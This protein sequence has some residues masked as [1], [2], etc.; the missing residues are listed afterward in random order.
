MVEEDKYCVDILVQ[1]Q[2]VINALH[3]VAEKIF[4]QHLETCV[5]EAFR[6]ESEEEKRRK[7]DE[8]IEVLRRVYR[9]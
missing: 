4:R 3:A 9:L 2:A 8:I 5:V 1:I 7:I 6:G